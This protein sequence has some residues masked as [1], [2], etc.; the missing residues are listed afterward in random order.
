[1]LIGALLTQCAC[2]VCDSQIPSLESSFD[3]LTKGFTA[4]TLLG[5]VNRNQFAS[6][7]DPPSPLYVSQT[8]PSDNLGCVRTPPLYMY[9]LECRSPLNIADD[10]LLW[11][12]LPFPFEGFN[13]VSTNILSLNVNSVTN[14][15]VTWDRISESIEE[16]TGGHVRTGTNTIL[17]TGG[18]RIKRKLYSFNANTPTGNANSPIFS[19]SEYDEEYDCCC[20]CTTCDIPSGPC[21]TRTFFTVEPDSSS[22][23]SISTLN[24]NPAD[25]YTELTL[26]YPGVIDE[27]YESLSIY[28][29]DNAQNNARIWQFYSSPS[30]LTLSSSDGNVIGCTGTL[31]DVKN[32]LQGFSAFFSS[33]VLGPNLALS[34]STTVAEIS[35]LPT[36][37]SPPIQRGVGG[38]TGL[39]VPLVFPGTISPPSTYQCGFYDLSD[40][41]YFAANYSSVVG[42]FSYDETLNGYLNYLFSKRH[43]YGTT[44]NSGTIGNGLYLIDDFDSQLKISEGTTWSIASIPGICGSTL[45]QSYNIP[46]FTSWLGVIELTFT[47]C[48]QEGDKPGEEECFLNPSAGI[49]PFCPPTQGWYDVINYNTTRGAPGAQSLF[50]S[51]SF[52]GYIDCNANLIPDCPTPPPLSPENEVCI[53]GEGTGTST[54]TT[55]P[56]GLTSA[57]ATQ[58]LYG[59]WYLGT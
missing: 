42:T 4:N 18:I 11:N 21:P 14:A 30:G 36:F 1:M 22:S 49:P 31:T 39:F 37:V 53:C 45:I 33:V 35:D 9:E 10:Y 26:K 20:G 46:G 32:T 56:E 41:P 50:N 38:I 57:N 8:I 7:S 54:F 24:F 43:F 17:V 55:F 58:I 25:S 13:A 47:W 5:Y 40:N 15:S 28:L 52:P 12:P 3:K 19:T 59:E 51:P 6:P 44:F 48:G 34:G 16:T 29:A 2:G 23:R 27:T